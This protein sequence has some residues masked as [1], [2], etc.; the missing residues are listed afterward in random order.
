[1]RTAPK[2]AISGS[3]AHELVSRGG[4]PWFFREKSALYDWDGMAVDFEPLYPFGLV[5]TPVPGAAPSLADV[6]MTKLRRLA[7][8]NSPVVLRGFRDSTDRELFVRKAGE[9]GTIMP[10]NKDVNEDDANKPWK[11]GVVFEVKD[12]GLTG[13]VSDEALPMHYDGV[14]KIEKQLD[15]AGNEVSISQAP[16]CVL[17]LVSSA[18]C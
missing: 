4:Q 12:R 13:Q 8:F 18:L 3:A 2:A 17:S 16:R 11:F 7:E 9:L 5:V 1:M 6:D 10:W 15:Q 14:F